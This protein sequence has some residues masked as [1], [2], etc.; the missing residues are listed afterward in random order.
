M[1][2][3]KELL[4]TEKFSALHLLDSA[5]CVRVRVCV[6]II[7]KCYNYTVDSRYCGSLIT[8]P[9]YGLLATV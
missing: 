2:F 1:K 7:W 6:C 9:W 4:A 3:T 8:S 5:V